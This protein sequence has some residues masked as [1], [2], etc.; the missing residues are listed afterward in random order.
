MFDIF[1]YTTL[2]K[3]VDVLMDAVFGV[4]HNDD[5]EGTSSTD[6][7]EDVNHYAIHND[8]NSVGDEVFSHLDDMTDSD[9][10]CSDDRIM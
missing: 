9:N 2:D 7:D 8:N 3:E 1:R 4:D 10:S 5:D 6:E